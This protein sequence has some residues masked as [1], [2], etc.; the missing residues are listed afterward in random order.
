MSQLVIKYILSFF[1]PFHLFTKYIDIYIYIYLSILHLGYLLDMFTRCH[2]QSYYISFHSLIL[3][4]FLP[5]YIDIYI[6]IYLSIYLTPRVY[7]KHVYKMSQL[8][9]IYILS[10]FNPFYLSTQ[11]INIYISIY[12]SIYFTL[13]VYIRHVYKMKSY[14]ISFYL[15]FCLSIYLYIYLYITIYLFYN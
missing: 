13:L 15:S 1:N 2:S 7:I 12:L 6:S 8:V 4:I 11:Y 5:K 10:F 14:Y 3:P 9:I